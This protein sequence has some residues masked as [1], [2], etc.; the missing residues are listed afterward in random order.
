MRSIAIATLLAAT[1]A[2][3]AFAQDATAP[4]TGPRIEALVGVDQLRGLGHN[5]GVTYGAGAGYDVQVRGPNGPIFGI[6][7]SLTDSNAK[8]CAGA[9][10]SRQCQKAGR[11]IYVG[12]RV[13]APVLPKTLIY[14]KA[15]YT[16]ASFS[17][18]NAAGARLRK[19]DYDGW[20]IG[21]GLEYAVTSNM[22]VKAEATVSDYTDGFTRRQAVAGFGMRF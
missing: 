20:R 13:G 7:A 9:A 19:G 10:A 22:F 4:F 8:L 12:G 18:Y 14:A 2:V 1:A 6:E 3:P 11:D 5:E 21:G 17:Q 16:N 15:G